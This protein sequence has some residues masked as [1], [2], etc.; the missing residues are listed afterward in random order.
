MSTLQK[1]WGIMSTYTKMSG[2]RGCPPGG[3]RGDIVQHLHLCC[4]HNFKRGDI[5]EAVLL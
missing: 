3:W 5:I 1:S 4:L 2:G